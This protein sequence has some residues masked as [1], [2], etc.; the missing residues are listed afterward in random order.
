MKKRTTPIVAIVYIFILSSL[1][2]SC[3]S[4]SL[5]PNIAPTKMVTITL[6][7]ASVLEIGST[8]ELEVE[9][10]VPVPTEAV[11]PLTSTSD[12]AMFRA[13]P[14]H[15]GVYVGVGPKQFDELLWKFETDGE[16]T[17]SPAVLDGVVYFGSA[18]G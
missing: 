3:E 15:T 18:D 10:E 9:T 8:Q 6:T 2:C 16:V 1:A 11:I 4:G 14:A 13:N 12:I 7:P 5:P 17:S